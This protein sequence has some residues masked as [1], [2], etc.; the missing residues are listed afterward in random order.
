M[1][2]IWQKI[3]ADIVSRPLISLLILVTIVTSSALLTLALATLININAPYDRAFDELNA[4]HVWLHFD[5]D[6]T[7]QRDI[8]RI[9]ALPNV[10]ESTGLRYN[11][12]TRV[13]IRDTHFGASLQAIPLDPP[14][15]N[16]LLIQEG[17]ALALD[18]VNSWPA[19][20]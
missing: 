13:R 5:R 14:V 3:K 19:R 17:R 9:E 11:I 8:E 12:V 18:R 20:T 6:R 15:V 10:V 16:R 4:A 2:A 1:D 7:R